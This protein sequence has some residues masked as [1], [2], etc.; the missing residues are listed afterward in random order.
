MR[1][2]ASWVGLG[3]FGGNEKFMRGLIVLCFTAA[4]SVSTAQAVSLSFD[5]L[6]SSDDQ[7]QFFNFTLASPGAATFQTFGYGG[8][9]NAL[10]DSIS[11]GGFESLLSW[12]DPSD[13]YFLGSAS[14]QCGAGNNSYADACLDVYATTNSLPA[15]TYTLALTQVGNYANSESSIIDD[16]SQGFVEQ[17][18]GSYTALNGEVPNCTAFCG[19]LGTQENGDWAVDILNVSSASEANTTPEPITMVL[20]GCGLALIGLARRRFAKKH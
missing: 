17:G 9:E 10:G 19:T 18:Q 12:F 15:G 16:L 2:A 7:I 20:G 5:G 3:L 13:G 14:D 11:S 8:G 6:F 4:I 1:T